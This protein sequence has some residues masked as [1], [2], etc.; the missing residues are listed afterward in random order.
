MD[1]IA[2]AKSKK[3]T[4]ESLIGGGAVKGKNCTISS[5]VKVDGNSTVTFS[6]TLDNGTVKTGTMT[7]KDG[8][9]GED[10]KDGADG[11]GIKNIDINTDGKLVITY[12]DD[13][14][15]DPIEMPTADVEISKAEGNALENKADGLYVGATGVQ[16]SKETDNVIETKSDGLYVKKTSDVEI[17]KEE[18][19]IIEA[20]SDG[21]YASADE[22]SISKADKNIIEEKEDGL[23]VPETDLSSYAKK[24]DLTSVYKYK[25]SV[26]KASD[27]PTDDLT[28]GDVYNIEETGM[29]V[30]WTGTAW[31]ELG[32]SVDLSAYAK[33]ADVVAKAQG[34]ANKGKFLGIGEDGNVAPISVPTPDLTDYVKSDYALADAGTDL[35]NLKSN[36]RYFFLHNRTYNNLPTAV[37]NGWLDVKVSKG[38]SSV[39]KQVF[40]RQGTNNT[41]D[42]EVY[43]R[44]FSTTWSDWVRLATTKDLGTKHTISYTNTSGQ[45]KS[46]TVYGS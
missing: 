14:Q 39:I 9:R 45:S 43:V 32:T 12:D 26:T 38:V 40:F 42:F 27:L 22:V 13:T 4:D 24:T 37:V 30:A 46:I 33:S 7:V 34:E 3:Y 15:S 16:I 36:G 18:G 6:W 44:T 31:D 17:S 20:K 19:N 5:I 8:A 25:G 35:N 2:Y 28:V 1:L 23:Y 11:K 41:N 10:G 21:L 29:N